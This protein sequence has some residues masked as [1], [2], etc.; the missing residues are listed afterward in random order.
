M[1]RRLTGFSLPSLP[2]TLSRL[3]GQMGRRGKPRQSSESDT[4]FRLF[5]VGIYCIEVDI[6]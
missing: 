4:G 6:R 5:H 1:F 3:R 2:P